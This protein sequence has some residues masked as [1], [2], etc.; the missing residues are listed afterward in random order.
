MADSPKQ[1]E[2]AQAL[3]SAIVDYLGKPIPML[4]NYNKFKKEYKNEISIVSGNVKTPGVTLGEIETFLKDDVEWFMSSTNIANNLF[5]ATKE[6][7]K[8]THNKIKPKGIEL[9]YVRGDKDVFGSLDILWKFTNEQT[10]KANDN[11][12]K[13]S[14]IFNDI[15][16]WNPADIYLA[17]NKAKQLLSELASNSEVSYK[18]GKFTI[19]SIDNFKDFS[20]L[21][22]FV[23]SLIDDGELLPLSLKKSPNS[24]TTVIK[25]INYVEG[26][27]EKQL[28]QQNIGYQG[29][30]FSKTD[31]VFNSKDIYIKFTDKGNLLQFRDKGSSGASKGKAPTYSYQGII[32][33]GKEAL[34][35]GLAGQ[36]IGDVLK[37]TNAK[38]G[39][40]FSLQNQKKVIDEAIQ[41]STMM[42]SGNFEKAIEHPI[43]KAVFKFVQNYSK[44]KYEDELDLFMQLSKNKKY[45]KKDL[46]N[47]T[48]SIRAKAQFLFSKYLGGSMIELFEKNK[49]L[50][51]EMTTNMI[52]YAGSR[53][54]S[55]SPHFKASDV[56]AF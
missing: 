22:L 10:K 54:S 45:T 20:I 18:I 56:S 50:A 29:Y 8:K 55:S 48:L 3:F 38:A 37:S 25:T 27:I 34:D 24:D 5:K 39:E 47:K 17:T 23:K 35:G 43:S 7:A 30:I 32:T 41:I 15:N 1:A 53:S 44:S 6:L 14:L 51:D 49:S 28:K 40:M 52:L 31:N 16:K 26:D 21:N 13:N 19:K 33:G 12:G 9:F 46:G 11:E 36:S 42:E 4:E 2:A